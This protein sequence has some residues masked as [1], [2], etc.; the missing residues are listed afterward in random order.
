MTPDE[1]DR[2]ARLRA[3]DEAALREIVRSYASR[4]YRVSF[5]ILRNHDDADEIAQE[6]F[7]KVYF[8][9][10][11]FKGRGS[12][13]AWIYRIAVN[14]CYRFLLKKQVKPVHPVDFA[15][16]ALPRRIEALP[17]G[18]STPDRDAMQRDFINGLLARIP[19]DDRWLLV[20]KEVEGFSLTELSQL[21]G[22]N[23]NA[24]RRRL[25]RIRQGLLEAA[26]AEYCTHTAS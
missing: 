7:A 1:I 12:L 2:V 25:F 13:Y 9:I 21:T 22:S 11:N 17:D 14:E 10:H 15:G 16:D 5:G 8:S 24:L 3:R 23:E 19:E 4:I 26:R 6:V 18:R 20:S